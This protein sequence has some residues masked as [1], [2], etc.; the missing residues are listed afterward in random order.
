MASEILCNANIAKNFF[1]YFLGNEIE[2]KIISSRKIP[3]V[4]H[5]CVKKRKKKKKKRKKE[6][7]GN[8]ADGRLTN[9]F[10]AE[11]FNDSTSTLVIDA[12]L[13]RMLCSVIMVHLTVSRVI[14]TRCNIRGSRNKISQTIS[15]L[16]Y[17]YI[18]CRCCEKRGNEVA[19]GRKLYQLLLPLLPRRGGEVKKFPGNL[20]LF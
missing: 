1:L 12:I 16:S 11:K 20:R 18:R 14:F 8:Y 17:L 4:S 10:S 19:R 7:V 13:Q 3:F 15:P 6:I 5:A 2:A 9:I